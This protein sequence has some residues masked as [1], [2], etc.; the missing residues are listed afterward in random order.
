MVIQ[1]PRSSRSP[2]PELTTSDFIN[3]GVYAFT[4]DIF[5]AIR[6]T[7]SRGG[8]VLTDA[9][10]E[11]VADGQLHDVMYRGMWQDTSMVWTC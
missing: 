1:L 6:Q 5:E 8:Q 10:A 3:T 2:S 9:L 7:G 4:R 11:Y